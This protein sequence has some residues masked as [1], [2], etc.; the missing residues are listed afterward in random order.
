MLSVTVHDTA[1]SK[2]NKK[3]TYNIQKKNKKNSKKYKI[4]EHEYIIKVQSWNHDYVFQCDALCDQ[5]FY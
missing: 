5:W 1:L 3:K 4:Q 2:E